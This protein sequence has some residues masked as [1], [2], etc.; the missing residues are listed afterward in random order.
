M[1]YVGSRI[2]PHPPAI[3]YSH[4]SPTRMA[5]LL[6]WLTYSH[7]SPSRMVHRFAWLTYLH[8]SPT[9]MASHSGSRFKAGNCVIINITLLINIALF[10]H[11][12]IGASAAKGRPWILSFGAAHGTA[13]VAMASP[14]T[15]CDSAATSLAKTRPR[16]KRRTRRSGTRHNNNTSTQQ[17]LYQTSSTR[18]ELNRICIRQAQRELNST[19]TESGKLNA[20]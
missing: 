6:A 12:S 4:G 8:G 2:S 16:G 20:N 14:S 3:P 1:F 7:G 18:T 15:A 11:Q 5:L 10:S 9:R 13:S 17:D 19:G